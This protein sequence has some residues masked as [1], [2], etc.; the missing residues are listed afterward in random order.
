M[1]KN[2]VIGIELG[3]A[4]ALA[5]IFDV[6]GNL[7]AVE[8]TPI[9]AEQGPKI[10]LT[11]M[12]MLIDEIMRQAGDARLT[13]IGIGC[14][15]PL[16]IDH[17]VIQ[18]PSILPTW[19]NVPLTA[20][21]RR[22]YRVPVILENDVDAIALGEYWMGAGRRVH[23]V[24]LVHTGS[25]IG[26]AFLQDGQ[27][28]RGS[29]HLHPEGGHIPLDPSGPECSCGSHGCWDSLASGKAMER[30]AREMVMNHP[31]SAIL[32]IAGGN[33]M[34]VNAQVLMD[35]V[36]A[37]DLYARRVFDEIAGCFC[38]GLITILNLFTPEVMILSG[39]IMQELDLFQP[40]IEKAVA[41]NSQIVPV[42]SIKIVPSTLGDRAGIY[43]AAYAVLK[44]L[45]EG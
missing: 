6:N 28:Y 35:G 14:G 8:E 42:S 5:G 10:G 9:Q 4:R 1:K 19:E 12:M 2:A 20:P 23:L 17:G 11:R 36:R 34:N 25:G 13:G 41:Q 18:N 38:Q 44:K 27:V 26:T 31:E 7:I 40:A 24:Y 3:G 39:E 15:G 21:L 37:G 45:G 43:G 22:Q 32:Q 33:L 16:D 29:H 30:R